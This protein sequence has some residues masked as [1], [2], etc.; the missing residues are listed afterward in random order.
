[1]NSLTTI[2]FKF[3]NKYKNLSKIE[4]IN[5]HKN[6]LQKLKNNIKNII[7][8]QATTVC[9]RNI[10]QACAHQKNTI[11]VH[12]FH[13][14]NSPNDFYGYG[15]QF[16]TSITKVHKKIQLNWERKIVKL[17][18][19][20]NSD[21]IHVHN[22]PDLMPMRIMAMD[23]GIPVIYDQH[24]FLSGKRTLNTELLKHEKYCNEKNDGAVFITD[25]YRDLVAS[26]YSINNLNISFPNFGS[27]EMI[28]KKEDLLPKLSLKSKKI[29]LVYVGA[30]DQENPNI[31]RYLIPQ[32]KE[33]SNQNFIIDIYPSQNGNYTK[34]E[35]IKNVN[36]MN[37]LNPKKL[38]KALS[39]YDCGLTLVNPNAVNMPEEL[40]FG[41]WNKTFD[42]LMAGIPQITLK[43]FT[44][45]SEFVEENG[46]GISTP[47]L[48]ELNKNH[49]QLSNYLSS[50]QPKIIE[51]NKNYTYES[52]INNM[53]SFYID[54]IKKYHNNRIKKLEK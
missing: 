31:T 22:E 52:Q 51:N 8:A 33:L 9:I 21:L 16:Y 30:I 42:Y 49:E 20:S 48:S 28:L 40:K 50:L 4:K 17:I 43:Q 27:D 15:N 11:N 2:M 53:H 14:G 12:L 44:V 10:K 54:V 5:F 18:N 7:Y 1:M 6:K 25:Y 36:V 38:I 3:K 19:Q 41:F 37:R 32:I 24:D 34:Y 46:F 39:Q 29:H 45:I 13:S 47:S 23:L 26:K 35:S